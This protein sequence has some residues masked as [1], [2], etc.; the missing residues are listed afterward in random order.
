LHRLIARL[1][2]G[3]RLSSAPGRKRVACKAQDDM[4]GEGL[5]TAEIEEE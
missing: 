3:K 5:W 1:Y 2:R 4:G